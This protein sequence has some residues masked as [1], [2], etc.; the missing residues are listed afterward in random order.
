MGGLAFASGAKPLFT[1]RMPPHV[2]RYVRDHC[3]RVLRQL[4]VCV[5]SPIEMPAKKD[6]GDIDIFLGWERKRMFPFTSANALPQGLPENPL[7]AAAHLLKAERTTNEKPILLTLAIPWPKQLLEPAKQA[8]STQNDDGNNEE[9]KEPRF[10]Q[11]DLH[12]Y[13]EL[14]QLQWML[15][16]HAHGDFWTI[17][18]S[19]IRPFGLTIGFY[20][21]YLRIPEIEH[22][23]RKKAR[24]LLTRDASEILSFLGFSS[25]GPH[26]EQPF[27]TT[28]ALFDYVSTC[29][30]WG[31][32]PSPADGENQLD[33]EEEI[34]EDLEEGKLNSKNRRRVFLRPLFQKW[35]EEYLPKCRE[36][37]RLGNIRIT[38]TDVRQDAF[39]RFGVKKEYEEQLLRW[40]IERQEQ[41]LLRDVIKP[42]LP[43]TLDDMWRG[44]VHSALKKIIMKDDEGFGIRPK[45]KLKNQD[46]LYDED[47]VRNFVW[48]HWKQVGDVAWE[49]NRAKYLEHLERKRLKIDKQGKPFTP[50]DSNTESS[51]TTNVGNG[52]GV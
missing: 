8:G 38:R 44:C 3:H 45:S 41:I 31:V 46:G 13:E 2:Y 27:P 7:R 40:R 48:A 21:L 36:A 17:L 51:K 24:I 43:E 18:G 1:P 20:G 4:F 19:I 14:P 9:V 30:F 5:V 22:E 28:E 49:Q 47:L 16:K 33:H 6:Y 35:V 12:W 32:R 42:I 52:G 37:G 23:N 25:S 11:V 10:I 15:F 26:W 39:V 50:E 29:R 34:G